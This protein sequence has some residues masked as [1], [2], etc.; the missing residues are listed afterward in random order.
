MATV[1]VEQLLNELAQARA[2]GPGVATT[3]LNVIGFVENDNRLLELLRERVEALG[4]IY[5]TRSVLLAGSSRSGDHTVRGEHV[6]LGTSR[7][8]AAELRSLT[9]DLLVPGVRSVLLWAG[10]HLNDERFTL[11]SELADTVVVFSSARDAG[12]GPLRELLALEAGAAAAA[13]KVR[14]LSYLRL[15]VWQD[16]IAQFFDDPELA[17]ELPSIAAVEVTAGS[18][19]EAYYLVGWLASRLK[20]DVCGENEFCNSQGATIAFDFRRAGALRRMQSVFLR[21]AHCTFGAALEK[22]ADDV[23]CLTVE[24]AK[25]RAHRCM[26][27]REVDMLSLIERA[28]FDPPAHEIYGRTLAMAARLLEHAR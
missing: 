25:S 2:D 4:A 21:T 5:A 18:M 11:L 17:A 23:V 14:D 22:E 27:L 6:E 28:I 20:W 3:S 26:P 24:G 16:L 7:V 15:H 13:R 12:L 19:P 10:E 1:N 9:H 8:S